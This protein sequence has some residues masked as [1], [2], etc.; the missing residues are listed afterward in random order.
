MYWHWW[1]CA[2]FPG[3]GFW[4]Y[5]T[6]WN[7]YFQVT[8]EIGIRRRH[9]K[10][11]RVPAFGQ[12]NTLHLYI[13]IERRNSSWFDLRFDLLFIL[14]PRLNILALLYLDRVKFTMTCNTLNPIFESGYHFQSSFVYTFKCL[15]PQFSQKTCLLRLA[16]I[17]LQLYIS[18]HYYSIVWW[19]SIS[20]YISA[21]WNTPSLDFGNPSPLKCINNISHHLTQMS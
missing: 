15:L 7:C 6:C 1:D 3:G 5:V 17:M 9:S 12:L 18:R 11:I 19:W 8:A 10:Q 2:V 13:F 14:G 21:W 4:Q 16:S 20:L